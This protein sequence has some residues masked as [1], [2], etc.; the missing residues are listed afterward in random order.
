VSSRTS[1]L[2]A[3][4]AL[5]FA[6]AALCTPWGTVDAQTK[7]ATAKPAAAKAAPPAIQ[8]KA[9]D[10]LKAS[11]AALAAAN[12][13][14]FNAIELFENPSR[15]RQPLAYT[16]RYDVLL[17]RPDKLRISLLADARPTNI[18]Y[19][20]KTVTAFRPEENLVAVQQAPP[21]IDAALAAAYTSS[22]T[23]F[24]FADVIV[25]NPYGDL[26][27]LL[28]RAYYVGRSK[29]VGDTETD[30]VAFMANGV[31][32][33]MWIGVDDKLPRM[34]RAVFLDDPA[35]RRH[36]LVFTNWKLNVDVAAD[37][38]TPSGTESAKH[39]PFAHPFQQRLVL[40]KQPGAAPSPSR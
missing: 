23:Y 28:K 39:I 5:A 30:I 10:L 27:P 37:A 7:P 34:I 2:R 35:Q 33:Q 24:P 6:A 17:Q 4:A 1:A 26:A 11:S 19:D 29:V 25:S 9:V 31:F 3:A 20:G 22:Q 13:L 16:N 32:E 21:T 18:W 12:A 8:T 36:E 15:Q 38:F 14:S 40:P